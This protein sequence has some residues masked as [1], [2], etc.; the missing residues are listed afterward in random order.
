L[1][2]HDRQ[3]FPRTVAQECGRAA[4]GL[5]E[6][7]RISYDSEADAAYIRLDANTEVGRVRQS[8]S[9]EAPFLSTGDVV[10]DFDR[11]GQLVAIEVLSASKLLPSELLA[12][13]ER[14]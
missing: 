14:H 7:V 2:D 9:V 1:N 5:G 3:L 6:K 4:A 12:S 11:D 10:L 13:A 8:V